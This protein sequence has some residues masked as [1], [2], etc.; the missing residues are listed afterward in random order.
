MS[1]QIKNEI[2]VDQN[3]QELTNWQKIDQ[4]EAEIE[5]SKKKKQ[6][7]QLKCLFS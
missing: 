1:K 2:K 3:T 7:L 5:K 4:L 6:M